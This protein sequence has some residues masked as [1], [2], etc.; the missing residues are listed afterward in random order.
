[1]LDEARKRDAM[2]LLENSALSVEQV[3]LRLGYSD[4]ANF[5]R[6][7]RKWSGFTPRQY[8]EQA[9]RPA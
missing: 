4:P 2:R 5:T 3:A 8:R 6:A 7:F 1:M 9:R